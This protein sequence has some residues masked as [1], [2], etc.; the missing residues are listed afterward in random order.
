MELQEDR[1]GIDLPRHPVD[2]AL[3]LTPADATDG[4]D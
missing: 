3:S 1:R 4:R 2:I